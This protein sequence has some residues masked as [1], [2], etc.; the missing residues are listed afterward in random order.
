MTATPT[1]TVIS[2]AGICKMPGSCPSAMGGCQAGLPSPARE[3]CSPHS[4][5]S[6][7]QPCVPREGRPRG[8]RRPGSCLSLLPVLGGTWTRHLC[9]SPSLTSLPPSGPHLHLPFLL[10]PNEGSLS[11]GPSSDLPTIPG[12]KHSDP[13][14]W[15]PL[16]LGTAPLLSVASGLII[17]ASHET[18][19]PGYLPGFQAHS[20]PN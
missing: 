19:P 15:C 4:L 11:L 10:L 17:Q 7:P 20:V 18:P 8:H 16:R 2:Q 5:V 13:Q 9:G 14:L 12:D 3:P 1:G 6:S